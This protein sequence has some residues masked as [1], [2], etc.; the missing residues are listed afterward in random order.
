MINSKIIEEEVDLSKI[1]A[2]KDLEM[3]QAV[4]I[5]RRAQII[6]EDIIKDRKEEI[7]IKVKEEVEVEVMGAKEADINKIETGE[8]NLI[9]V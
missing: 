7:E 4:E 2:R 5:E 3:H 8:E 1:K 9:R 6:G